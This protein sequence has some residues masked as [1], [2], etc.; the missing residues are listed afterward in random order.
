MHKR[1]KLYCRVFIAD[2]TGTETLKIEQGHRS[3]RW[4]R[5]ERCF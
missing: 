3:C 1:Q 2:Y 4:N 5:V